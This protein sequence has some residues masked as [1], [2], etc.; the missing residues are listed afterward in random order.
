MEKIALNQLNPKDSSAIALHNYMVS[1]GANLSLSDLKLKVK[2]EK[3][4]SILNYLRILK[5]L[6]IVGDILNLTIDELK[7]KKEILPAFARCNLKNG[8]AL[9]ILICDINDKSIIV[10]DDKNEKKEISISDFISAY[11]GKVIF[12]KDNKEFLIEYVYR[13]K[14]YNL[15][16]Y[17]ALFFISLGLI[18]VSILFLLVYIYVIAFKNTN[19]ETLIFLY[20]FVLVT[21]IFSILSAGLYFLKKKKFT[22]KISLEEFEPEKKMPDD[23]DEYR[24]ITHKVS[25]IADEYL[26]SS[27]DTGIASVIT[28]NIKELSKSDKKDSN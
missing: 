28:G 22:S 26:K 27:G 6:N 4:I 14:Y 20:I 10:K 21:I 9:Y 11:E 2:F 15:T 7:N 16:K 12:V 3:N 5:D 18:G 19:R 25:S 13:K 23:T 8:E 24:E 17:K 1:E